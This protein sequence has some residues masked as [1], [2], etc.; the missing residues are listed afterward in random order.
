MC[1]NNI[2][3]LIS[4]SKAPAAVGPYSHAYQAGDFLY[5]SGQLGL[6]PESGVLAEGGVE[7]ETK[8]AMNNVGAVLHAAGLD[9]THVIKTTLFITNMADFAA[10]NAIYAEYF[11]S[12]PPARSCVQV[13]ALPKGGQFE[14]EVIA[15]DDH[16]TYFMGTAPRM[17]H[18]HAD[19]SSHVH[20]HGD[21]SHN[22]GG[23]EH[24]HT[25]LDGQTHA[26][27]HDHPHDHTHE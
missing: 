5:C 26:H 18:T 25:H 3:R 9:Y 19:G 2:K 15:Y 7:A 12:N 20:E 22:H 13:A 1:G 21:H 23:H 16:S 11:P 4:A 14:I 27:G 8:Q 6:V 17:E 10:I 24:E